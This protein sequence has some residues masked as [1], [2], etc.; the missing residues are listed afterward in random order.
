MILRYAQLSFPC[1]ASAHFGRSAPLI[2]EIGF[3]NGSFL[4]ELAARHPE[5]NCLGVERAMAS[6]TRAFERLRVAGIQNV[7][8]VHANAY[9][10]LRDVVPHSSLQRIY[11][12]FPDPWPKPGQ[13]RHRLLQAP[14]WRLAASRLAPDGEFLITS[15]HE[16]YF[17]FAVSEARASNALDIELQAPDSEVLQSKYGQRWQSQAKRIQ[18][19]RL[20]P[21]AGQPSIPCQTEVVPMYHILMQGSFEQLGELRKSST[22]HREGKLMLMDGFRAM[23]GDRLLFEVMAV[24]PEAELRQDLLV[25]VRP[26]GNG[27]VVELTHFGSPVITRLTRDSVRLVADWLETQGWRTLQEAY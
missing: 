18:A 20:R 15:D 16:E 19:A 1:Q 3:G 17:A 7:R 13:Q 5:W 8:L 12:S 25:E 6:V 4:T 21:R 23:Y 9:W 24:E 22:D 11:V 14:F 27:M 10:F 2:L 26:S